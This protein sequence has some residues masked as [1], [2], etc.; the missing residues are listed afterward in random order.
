MATNL[1][2]EQLKSIAT[3]LRHDADAAD[4][5]WKLAFI[6]EAPFREGQEVEVG[7]GSGSGTRDNSYQRA[8]V[9]RVWVSYS[10][11]VYE[12]SV[13]TKAGWSKNKRSIYCYD[14][15]REVQA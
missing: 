5:A 11:I 12:V 2:V 8:I 10:Q 14:R 13:K 7:F 3:R 4:Q 15:I 6:K 1:T 9:R